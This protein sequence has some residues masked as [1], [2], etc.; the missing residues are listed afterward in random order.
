MIVV[1]PPDRSVLLNYLLT[2]LQKMITLKQPYDRYH[3]SHLLHIIKLNSKSA[4]KP[5]DLPKTGRY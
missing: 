5:A 3:L 1:P 4:G 2:Y